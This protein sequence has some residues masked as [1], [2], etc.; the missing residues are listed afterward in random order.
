LRNPEHCVAIAALWPVVFQAESAD[1]VPVVS[2]PSVLNGL[3]QPM[4]TR[5]QCSNPSYPI[6]GRILHHDRV[7]PKNVVSASQTTTGVL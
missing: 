1:A 3:D 2:R 7:K 5:T 6:D 4:E